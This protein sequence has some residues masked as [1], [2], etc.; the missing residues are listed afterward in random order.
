MTFFNDKPES[1]PN[2][3]FF[4]DPVKESNSLEALTEFPGKM[5]QCLIIK[6]SFKDTNFRDQKDY[7]V[8]VLIILT[9][10]YLIK[11]RILH[12]FKTLLQ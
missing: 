1:K 3:G 9:D 5:G 10:L 11:V 4:P 12:F 2:E 7:F 6:T 8:L